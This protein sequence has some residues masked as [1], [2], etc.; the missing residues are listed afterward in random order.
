M[1][2]PSARVKPTP[3]EPPV[4]VPT[5]VKEELT[6]ATG[7]VVPVKVLAAAAT[8]MA[9]VPS[10]VTPLIARG[11]CKAVAVPALPVTLA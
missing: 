10:K 1:L 7:K 6:T 8:V 11:V 4:K 2:V 3:V 9:V 5:A